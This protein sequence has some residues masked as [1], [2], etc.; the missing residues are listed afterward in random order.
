MDYNTKDKLIKYLSEFAT[1]ERV[2]LFNNIVNNRTNYISIALENLYQSHNASAVLR[3]CECLGVHNINIIEETNEFKVSSDIALGAGNWLNIK[4]YSNSEEALNDLKSKD[5]R[6]IATSSNI[7]GTSLPDFDI[8]KGKS[9]IFMGTE[10]HG[11]SNYILKNADEHLKIPMFGFT[12]S[13]NISVSAAI[14]LYTLCNKLRESDISW[15]L[16]ASEKQDIII[17]WL[18]KSIKKSDLLIKRF[19]NQ[20]QK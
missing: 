2:N 14:I 18:K 4:K 8:K 15:N 6:I 7:N 5:Y 3:S 11:L 13:Y 12:E 17:K 19:I 9:V 20:A 10:M 16:S 1:E